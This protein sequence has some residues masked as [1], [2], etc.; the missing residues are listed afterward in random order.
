MDIEQKDRIIN[1]MVEYK[2][3]FAK[4]CNGRIERELGHI[5]GAD[6]MM[7]RFNDILKAE[8]EKD[9]ITAEINKYER[10]K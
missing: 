6:Y 7:H 2:N 9:D 5:E 8:C 3:N 10:K 1:T 4:D